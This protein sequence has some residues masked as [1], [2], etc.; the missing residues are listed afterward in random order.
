MEES[1]THKAHEKTKQNKKLFLQFRTDLFIS[2]TSQ[3]IES[4]P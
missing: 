2:I 3:E 1:S 4:F